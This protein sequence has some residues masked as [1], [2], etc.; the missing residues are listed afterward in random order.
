VRAVIGDVCGHGPDEAAVG[1]ALRIA[2]RTMVLAGAEPAEV[3]RA[4]DEMLR[5]ESTTPALFATVCDITIHS[6]AGERHTDGNGPGEALATVRLHGHQP[7]LLLAPEVRFLDEGRPSPPLGV[8]TYAPAVPCTV[9]LGRRWALL[10]ATD[11]LHEARTRRGRLGLS[12]L[13]DLVAQ[14]PGWCEDP[15][16]ALQ[17]LLHEVIDG[18]GGHLTDDVALLWLGSVS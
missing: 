10:L 17:R 4:V 9:P 8:L 13:A 12:A 3:L 1:V 2:W 14:I 6:A 7:P 18:N 11:G 15:D 16:L 5:H